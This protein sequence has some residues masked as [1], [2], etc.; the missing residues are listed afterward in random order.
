MQSEEVTVVILA[1]GMGTRMKSR[2]AKVLHSAGGKTLIQHAVDSA[3]EV[4]APHRIFVVVGHQAERVQESVNDRGVKFIVQTE[5]RGT[6]HALLCGA[7][8][9][10]ALSGLLMIFYGDCPLILPATLKELVARQL[11]HS[12]AATLI[13]TSLEDPTGYGRVIRTQFGDVVAIVEQKAASAE[14]LGVREINAG[15]Y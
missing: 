2:H 4:A 8:E 15:I 13:S 6:G 12:A 9:L 10:A 14:Q 5:Q 7:A 3:L 1:A 11:G